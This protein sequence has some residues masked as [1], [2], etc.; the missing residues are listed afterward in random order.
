MRLTKQSELCNNIISC[1]AGY[2]NE[3]KYIKLLI[4][5]VAGGRLALPT[6]SPEQRNEWSWVLGL[7]PFPGHL[8]WG[9]EAAS[10][11]P[12]PSL[13]EGEEGVA[14]GKHVYT[15]KKTKRVE[16]DLKDIEEEEDEGGGDEEGKK[17]EWDGDSYDDE[18][19]DSEKDDE[20]GWNTDNMR[21]LSEGGV[22]RK[23]PPSLYRNDSPDDSLRGGGSSPQGVEEEIL[24]VEGEEEDSKG[25]RRIQRWR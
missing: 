6:L 13:L 12:I 11:S 25:R 20:E 23:W 22:I 17:D 2:G 3:S 18:D 14:G 24:G 7:G 15:R 10:S 1:G 9:E 19:E 4:K 21:W 8:E 5:K 16:E